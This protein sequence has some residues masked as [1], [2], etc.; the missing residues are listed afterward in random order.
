[1]LLGKSAWLAAG[2]ETRRARCHMRCARRQS[3]WA[4]RRARAWAAG[5]VLLA[6]L[7]AGG[8]AGCGETASTEGPAEALAADAVRDP[9]AVAGHIDV[10]G[11]NIAAKSL[12]K[13]VPDFNRRHPN[14]CVNVSM[15]GANLQSRFLLSLSAGV[16]APDVSQL[17][18]TDAPK[19]IATGRLTDLT[20]VAAKYEK[21]FSP[22]LWRNCIYK[23]RVYAIPWDMGPC[24]VYYKRDLFE[25]YGV[26][27][28]G[29]E[30]WDD[31]IAAGRTILEKSG[32]RT[33][34]LPLAATGLG[35]M[36][37]IL[38]QQNGGQVFD[39]EGRIAVNSPQSAQVL[40][41]LR[42]LVES[43][44]CA[45]VTMW[46]H[47]F[48]AG[49]K[50]ETI[51]TYPMAV[52]FGGTI[53]DT[54]QE[55][56]GQKARWGVFRLPA[57]QGGGLRTSNLGG[58]VLVIPEQCRQKAAAWAF[59]EYALCTR[60]GQ[61]AQYRNYDLFPAFLPA[62]EDPFF[63]EPDPFYDGQKASRLFATDLTKIPALNRTEDWVEATRYLEQSLTRW[64]AGGMAED[65]F[66][67]HLEQKLR[68]RI[69]RGVSPAPAAEARADAY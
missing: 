22:S 14:V 39:E 29:I 9:Q 46:S 63:D 47:E 55:Y 34:M 7:A 53:K 60:E 62:L 27:P 44:I 69:G 54:V 41:T 57:L 17:Q 61:L 31:F 20:A 48:L 52:W 33:K 24:A 18:M 40:A 6:A 36:F 5:A 51:A 32:G 68:R 65:G 35:P 23:G 1:M 30:T 19:Y 16:G 45:N 10:W 4:G 42:R 15:T 58:S 25:R 59:I 43:G 2:R 11:W 67:A 3:G 50:S 64:A 28:E 66:F 37:E 49:L 8:A 12:G 21:M 56:A 38:L 13:L 26:D